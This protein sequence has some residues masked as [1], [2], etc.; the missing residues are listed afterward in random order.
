MCKSEECV[1]EIITVNKE[2]MHIVIY[3]SIAMYHSVNI[4]AVMYCIPSIYLT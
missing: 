3:C 4:V 1:N 2:V